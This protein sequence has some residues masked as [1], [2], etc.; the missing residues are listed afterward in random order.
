MNTSIVVVKIGGSLLLQPSFVTRLKLKLSQL[1]NEFSSAHFVLITGGGPLVEALRYIDGAHPLT[2]EFAHWTAIHL[3]DVNA[4]LLQDWWPELPCAM[5]MEA[6]LARLSEPGC[7]LFGVEEFLR[8]R[9][10]AAGGLRLTVGWDVTSDSI[11]ARCAEILRAE[12]LVL[13]KSTGGGTSSNWHKLAAD[14]RVD[15][16][17]PRFAARVRQVSLETLPE[18]P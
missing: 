1:S 14:G 11:A 18:T 7:T 4:R 12:K 16:A 9:E 8:L 6:L 15:P 10:P 3:M 5:S 13:L 17:F 2:D